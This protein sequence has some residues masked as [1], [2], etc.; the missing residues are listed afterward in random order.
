[1]KYVIGSGPAG[2]ACAKALL[3]RGERVIMLDAGITLENDRQAIINKMSEQPFEEWSNEDINRLKENSAPTTEGLPKKYVYGSDY[4]YRNLETQFPMETKDC[5]CQPTFAQGGL[6]TAWGAAVMPYSQDDISAWPI[7]IDTLEPYYKKVFSFVPLATREDLLAEK[8]PLYAKKIT[9]LNISK[10]A[11]HLLSNLEINRNHLVNDGIYSCHARLAVASE[12]ACVSCGMCMYGCPYQIIYNAAYTLKELQ[13]QPKFTY[14]SDVIVDKVEEKS[15][16][17][18]IYA[19]KMSTGEVLSFQAEHVFI[20]AGAFASTKIMLQTLGWEDKPVIMKDSQSFLL[21]MLLTKQIMKVPTERLHTLPQVFL[22]V[23][24]KVDN[25]NNN[26]NTNN[27]NTNNNNT[28]KHPVHMQVYTYNELYRRALETKLGA[29]AKL[30]KMPLDA[31][32]GRIIIGMGFLHSDLSPSISVTLHEGKLVLEKIPNPQGDKVVDA[33]VQA[34]KKNASRIGARPVKKM[35]K[36][37]MTGKSYHYGGTF[38]MREH[39]TENESDI[40][41]RPCGLKRT[42]LIDSSTFPSIPAT[43][44][45][46]TIMANAYRIGTEYDKFDHVYRRDAL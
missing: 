42:Y 12:P 36:P 2:V 29:V 43:T 35:L 41:G 40:L 1:M 14:K 8:F 5:T 44:I 26:N 32:L 9:K 37:A 22:E 15:R 39:P 11:M 38:P 7:T 3:E 17:V 25:S 13:A 33:T 24:P 19:H 30:F 28:N 45:S 23:Y 31:V 18:I 6:T 46:L 34:L 10:Q 4:T 16:Y 27:N 21:P 20:G